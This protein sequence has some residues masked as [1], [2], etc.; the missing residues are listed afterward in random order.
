MAASL[1]AEAKW[2]QV[3]ASLTAEDSLIRLASLGASSGWQPKRP[4]PVSI[5]RCTGT[6][7]SA[8]DSASTISSLQTPIEQPLVAA[9][10]A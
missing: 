7:S 10:E 3:P 9:A 1:S 8:R 2:V 6:T 4:M 5:F